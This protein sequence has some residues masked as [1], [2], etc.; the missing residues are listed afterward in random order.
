M[1]LLQ[2]VVFAETADPAAAIGAS[3]EASQ[4]R[5]IIARLQDAMP[6]FE[7]LCRNFP[8]AFLPD[9]RAVLKRFTTSRAP[10][11]GSA[12]SAGSAG[13]GGEEPHG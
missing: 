12:G 3:V 4:D 7:A 8:G 1:V 11:K 13:S 10:G 5:R 2:R 6:M 9:A